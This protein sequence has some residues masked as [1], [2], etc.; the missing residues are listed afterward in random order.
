MCHAGIRHS[1]T[2]KWHQSGEALAVKNP[3]FRQV[4]LQ[5]RK[6][7]L[8]L[9]WNFCVFVFSFE[10]RNC[11]KHHLE[12]VSIVCTTNLPPFNQQMQQMED[13]RKVENTQVLV[14]FYKIAKFWRWNQRRSHGTHSQ[15]VNLS[16]FNPS[17]IK[18]SDTFSSSL[19]F[20][21]NFI[22]FVNIVRVLATKIRETNAGRYDTR[23]QYRFVLNLFWASLS[24]AW[25]LPRDLIPTHSI[26]ILIKIETEG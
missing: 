8:D 5:K 16:I 21:L 25:T 7:N 3:S 4:C 1:L 14:F 9:V 24:L 26:L 20:Q 23:K 10:Q 19:L 22:L 12:S 2:S 13:F 11:C 6:K 15:E 18:S 17:S